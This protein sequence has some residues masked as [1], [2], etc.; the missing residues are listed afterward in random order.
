MDPYNN[1]DYVLTVVDAL[2]HF[3]QF[4]ACQKGITGEGVMKLLLERWIAPF[5][6]PNSLHS[7]NDVRFKS[8]KGFYQSAF[9]ALD[10][11]THF[12]IPRHPG[13][14]GLCENE[15]RAFL[16]NMRALSL[17]CKTNNWP[18]LVPY[19]TW[20]MN[21][22]V[23]PS[24]GLSPHEMFHGKPSWKL[25]FV[26]EPNMNPQAHGWL[27]EQILIQEKAVERL[28]KL[29]SSKLRRVN[30]GRVPNS[31]QVG[32]YVLVHNKRWPQHHWPKLSSPWQGPFKILKVKFNSL[33]IM[34]SPS[35]GGMI[36]VALHMCK[37]WDVELNNENFVDDFVEDVQESQQPPTSSNDDLVM[38]SEEQAQLGFYNV[39]K[40]LKH[41]FQ[42]G[43]KFLVW[44]ENFPASASTWEPISA[45]MLPNGS[46]N[47]IFKDY[48][49][50]N[51]LTNV[52]QKALSGS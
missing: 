18:Q 45:F 13:S 6:K 2:S 15:N 31:F 34:A 21:S 39:Y 47:T 49:V 1:F 3:S 8:E 38:S 11:E 5:G 22:Q 30:K 33:Q 25:E 20:L 12:A 44:W 46:I 41:K 9:K 50:E 4:Y 40:I 24:T 27:M 16:Q 48:C 36:D 23:S 26:P 10:I 37:R 42:Q 51:G 19:C 7:D 14:N 29:R 52:L 43:W 35:L 17:S 32:D 28:Q